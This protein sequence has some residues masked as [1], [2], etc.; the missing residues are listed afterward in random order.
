MLYS[1][2]P[3][4][5][6]GASWE[7]APVYP[8]LDNFADFSWVPYK[9]LASDAVDFSWAYYTLLPYNEIDFS[10]ELVKNYTYPVYSK[11]NAE[12]LDPPFEYLDYDKAHADFSGAEGVFKVYLG[13]TAFKSAYYGSTSV[14]IYF[15][16]VQVFG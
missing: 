1:V 7:E 3:Y 4:D 15:G 16:A 14:K 10:W 6:A 8:A 13:N 2:L 9:Q 12:W 5:L 11:A